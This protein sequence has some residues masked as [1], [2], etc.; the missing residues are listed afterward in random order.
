MRSGQS[1]G[2]GGLRVTATS[3]SCPL[4]C[5]G[6]SRFEARPLP[7][8]PPS[9][10]TPW[11]RRV[12]RRRPWTRRHRRLGAGARPAPAPPAF[13]PARPAPCPAPRPPPSRSPVGARECEDPGACGLAGRAPPGARLRPHSARPPHPERPGGRRQGG[14]GRGRGQEAAGHDAGGRIHHSRRCCYRDASYRRCT[15]FCACTCGPSTH[16]ATKLKLD[17]EREKKE[18]R[19]KNAVDKQTTHVQCATLV[20]CVHVFVRLCHY[21]MLTYVRKCV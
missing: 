6:S 18:L 13:S 11:G 15:C 20:A 16:K 21:T 8:P 4:A 7:T 17:C 10:L 19:G 2:D 5:S 14:P 9:Q 1:C 12:A 3:A